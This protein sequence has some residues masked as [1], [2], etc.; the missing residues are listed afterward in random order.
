MASVVQNNTTEASEKNIEIE[1]AHDR[2]HDLWCDW[3]FVVIGENYGMWA[4]QA[5]DLHPCCRRQYLKPEHL[6]AAGCRPTAAA[7]EHGDQK[8]RGGKPAPC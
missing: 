2:V 6:D 5:A 7:N 8:Q 3:T 1:E 4:K